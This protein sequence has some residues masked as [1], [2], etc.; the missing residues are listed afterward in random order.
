[1]DSTSLIQNTD[2]ERQDV[3]WSSRGGFAFLFANGFV[4]LVT[5]ALTFVLPLKM[6][7]FLIIWQGAVALPLAFAL[8]RV[9]KFPAVAKGNSLLPLLIQTAMVQIVAIPAVILAY[10]L[11]PAYVP[12][13]FAAIVGA[14][15]LPYAWLQK[16]RLYLV[17]S[18]IVSFVPYLM[19]MF[20]HET[21]FHYIGFVIGTVLIVFAF[22]LKASVEKER[23]DSVL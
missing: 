9:L 17:L 22:L 20:L 11:I 1:M 8:E 3:R 4:W 14:H 7:A 16:S 13:V 19:A 6:A 2:M 18:I 10:V 5:A 15:L 12:A 23:R 21:S